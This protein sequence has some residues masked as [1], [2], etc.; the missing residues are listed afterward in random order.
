METLCALGSPCLDSIP[1]SSGSTASS[2]EEEVHFLKAWEVDIKRSANFNARLASLMDGEEDDLAQE[3]CIRLVALYRCR[4]IIASNYVRVAIKNSMLRARSRTR[5][6]CDA[7]HRA[8]QQNVIGVRCSDGD[9]LLEENFVPTEAVRQAEASDDCDSEYLQRLQMG[10]MAFEDKSQDTV[11]YLEVMGVR[12]WIGQ[13]PANLQLIY[14]SI[15]VHGL[16]QRETAAS[17]RV[18]Q[19]R[20]VE[21]HRL[22]LQRGRRELAC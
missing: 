9:F 12:R 19:P 20:V 6:K 16:T 11:D 22:L 17:L 13:L 21:L 2:S 3:A 15:Y 7:A 4:K 18:S 8:V 14:Y 10:S 5:G 1:S